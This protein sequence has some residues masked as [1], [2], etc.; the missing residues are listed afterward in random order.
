MRYNVVILSISCFYDYKIILDQLD[1]IF[2]LVLMKT[3]Y[4][5]NAV[6]E[7]NVHVR[8]SLGIQSNSS[9]HWIDTVMKSHERRSRSR[10]IERVLYP[11]ESLKKVEN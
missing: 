2:C 9:K 11:A 6:E 10:S 1:G 5:Y 8:G 4:V 3:N 7:Y